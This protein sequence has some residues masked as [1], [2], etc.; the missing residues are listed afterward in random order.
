MEKIVNIHIEN[1]PKE[2]TLRPLMTIRD[3][4]FREEQF[5]KRLK[6]QGMWLKN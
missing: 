2:F 1:C 5:P 4:L 3:W 6:L